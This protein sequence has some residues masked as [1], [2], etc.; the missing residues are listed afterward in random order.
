MAVFW[1]IAYYP[2][3][4]NEPKHTSRLYIGKQCWNNMSTK[5]SLRLHTYA[6]SNN[7][8]HSI[9]ETSHACCG[10]NRDPDI[11]QDPEQFS[12]EHQNNVS[13]TDLIS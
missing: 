2:L 5:S 13:Q 9:H 1:R 12:C 7:S 3:P 4:D 6:K 11:L 8:L 10:V